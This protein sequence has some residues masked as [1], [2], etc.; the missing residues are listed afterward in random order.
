MKAMAAAGVKANL[1][2]PSNLSCTCPV[3]HRGDVQPKPKGNHSPKIWVYLQFLPL[4]SSCWL[5]KRESWWI[6]SV[7][8]SQSLRW[9]LGFPT[10][11]FAGHYAVQKTLLLKIETEQKSLLPHSPGRAG[12]SLLTIIFWLNESKSRTNKSKMEGEPARQAR[13]SRSIDAVIS[14]DTLQSPCYRSPQIQHKVT[15]KSPN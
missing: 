12:Q 4:L 14:R 9:P 2:T 10:A 15:A 6:F 3:R 1:K 7:L 11:G 8:P 5:G 13:S